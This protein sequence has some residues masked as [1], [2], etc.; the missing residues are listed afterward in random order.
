LY[1]WQ[2][3]EGVDFWRLYT[4]GRTSKV[5]IAPNRQAD[6]EEFLKRNNIV[7]EIYIDDLSEPVEEERQRMARNRQGRASVHPTSSNPDFSVF[8]SSTEMEQFSTFLAA[9]YPQF[10][11]METLGFSPSG[12]RRIYAMKFSTGTFGQKPIVAMECGMHAR[13]WVKLLFLNFVQL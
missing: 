2:E 4:A 6:F 13:E 5:M 9:T 7:N 3:E 1:K 11:T 12:G 10:V 8:W